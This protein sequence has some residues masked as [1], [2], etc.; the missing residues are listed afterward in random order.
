MRKFE[1]EYFES[2]IHKIVV[3]A[4]D[5][6]SAVRKFDELAGKNQIDFSRGTPYDCSITRIREK[7]DEDVQS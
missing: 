2:F 1:I 5:R 3:E 6:E 4:E 7:C